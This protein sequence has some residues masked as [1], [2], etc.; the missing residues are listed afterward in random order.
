VTLTQDRF[1]PVRPASGGTSTWVDAGPAVPV[2]SATVTAPRRVIRALV[3]RT[4][5]GR[6][7]TGGGKILAV[8]RYAA[9]RRVADSRGLPGD[10]LN[11][12]VKG[13]LHG[14]IP[15][16]YPCWTRRP[17]GWMSPLLDTCRR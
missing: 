17:C 13:F 8:L 16:P 10:W 1:R 11:D 5:A 9:A 15:T 12:P 6:G 3:V 4:T 14:K 7:P 2:T